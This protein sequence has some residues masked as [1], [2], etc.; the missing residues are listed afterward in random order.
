MCNPKISVSVEISWKSL[1]S[2][3]TEMLIVRKNLRAL[4]ET[5]NRQLKIMS[6]EIT[7]HI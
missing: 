5:P 6:F 7:I 4:A 3:A 1:R 2:A